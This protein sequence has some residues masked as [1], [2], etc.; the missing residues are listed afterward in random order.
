MAIRDWRLNFSVFLEFQI[1]KKHLL[2]TPEWSD[3]RRLKL[4]NP[5]PLQLFTVELSVDDI[6]DF[7][8]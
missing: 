8:M 2:K 7:G 4:Q 1:N 5:H 6:K 3:T